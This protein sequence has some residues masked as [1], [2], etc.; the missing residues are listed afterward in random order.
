M[1]GIPL[2]SLVQS[3]AS[4]A[5]PTPTLDGATLTG[6]YLVN[7][8]DPVYFANGL[9][10]D[11]ATI[12]LD[13]SSLRGQVA[14]MY[15]QGT[16]TLGGAGTVTFAG[17]GNEFGGAGNSSTTPVSL[18]IGSGIKIVIDQGACV[19]GRG[20]AL[21]LNQGLINVTNRSL[22]LDGNW[23]NQGTINLDTATLTLAGNFK[24][25]TIGTI[26][27]TSTSSVFI[28][29]VVDNTGKSLDLFKSTGSVYLNG[30]IVGGTISSSGPVNSTYLGNSGTL[31]GVGLGSDL[32]LSSGSNLHITNG[33]SLNGHRLGLGNGSSLN[34]T[35]SAASSSVLS[36]P[37][38]IAIDLTPN[39][40]TGETTLNNLTIPAGVRIAP[41]SLGS[42]PSTV[43]VISNFANSGE[44]DAAANLPVRLTG[45]WTNQGTVINN[46][47][48]LTLGGTFKTSDIGSVQNNS[49]VVVLEGALDNH[50]ATFSPSSMGGVTLNSGQIAGGTIGPASGAGLSVNDGNN[51]F[52]DGVTLAS[53]VLMNQQASIVVHGGLTLSGAVVDMTGGKATP[54]SPTALS[55]TEPELLQGNGTINF[56]GPGPYNAIQSY[57]NPLTIG[58]GVAINVSG[59]GT[60]TTTLASGISLQGNTSIS[61]TGS[62]TLNNVINSGTITSAGGTTTFTGSWSNKNGSFLQ[63]AAGGVV[64]LAAPFTIADL[65]T[66]NNSVGSINLSG[67]YSNSNATLDMSTLTGPWTLAGASISGGTINSTDGYALS[68]SGGANTLSSVT[69]NVPLKL[70][71]RANLTIGGSSTLVNPTISLAGGISTINTFLSLAAV[72]T[73]SGTGVISFD[74]TT[75]FSSITVSNGMTIGQGIKVTTGTAGGKLTGFSIVN[76]GTLAA[77]NN[78]TL[79]FNGTLNQQGTLSVGSGGTFSG[80]TIQ[81]SGIFDLE[82]GGLISASSVTDSATSNVIEMISG[83]PSPST[84]GR[85]V[86]SGTISLAGS[87]TVNFA[88]DFVPTTGDQY[89]LM[90][91][92]S[93]T[94]SFTSLSL[95]PAGANQRYNLVYT[96]TSVSLVVVPEPS[97]SLTAISCGLLLAKRRRRLMP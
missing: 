43:L 94:G 93:L 83:D 72:Q 74:G 88:P 54:Q 39:T 41:G 27:R 30:T 25:S 21:F 58:P 40:G 91:G 70:L 22:T 37:G 68:A 5:D 69:L 18:T 81:N 57:S 78:N 97:A 96:P 55:F 3:R 62:L 50:N 19:L 33:L 1:V 47:G 85:V 77:A 26:N 16:E 10:L 65:G 8:G 64:N 90:S 86:A 61:K 95:P 42:A 29:G 87:L 34:F 48:T 46:G 82:P 32:Q 52:S 20:D 38:L 45:T 60:I 12:L 31:S 2:L 66:F 6:T 53:S 13:S 15:A 79:S 71:P 84:Y 14:A 89:L 4:F 35:S 7:T 56:N 92:K 28:N 51:S 24:S 36:G 73:L 67:G 17:F 59:G 9:T 80:L 23:Q 75:S 49:G 11:D 44:I 76:K 63:T